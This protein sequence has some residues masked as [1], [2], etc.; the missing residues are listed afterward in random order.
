MFFE[1]ERGLAADGDPSA[2]SSPPIGDH[3]SV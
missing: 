1:V 2:E 3:Q